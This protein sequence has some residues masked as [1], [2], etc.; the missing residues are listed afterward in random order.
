MTSERSRFLLNVAASLCQ[1]GAALATSF[2]LYRVFVDGLGV[3]GTGVWVLVATL[4]D[5]LA[6]AELG[7]GT[8]VLKF[9][10]EARGRGDEGA[11]GAVMRSSF[12]IG[13]AAGLLVLAAGG[14]LAWGLP[15]W[16]SIDA[17]LAA[18]ARLAVLV[19]AVDIALTL[20]SAPFRLALQSAQRFDVVNWVYTARWLV[21][22]AVLWA[23]LTRWPSL[24]F[25]AAV[26]L[27]CNLAANVA[28]GAAAW[29]LVPAVRAGLAR[30]AAAGWPR[31]IAG[32]AVWVAVSMIAS[33]LAYA[34]DAVLVGVFLG[35]REVALYNA[36]WRIV[37]V[38]R[39]IGQAV[40]PFFLPMA[41]ERAAGGR[42]GSVPV[43]F[44]QGVRLVVLV[45]Y[46]LVAVALGA[47]DALLA[48]WL[49]DGFAGVF[50]LLWVLLVPQV[51]IMTMYPSGPIAYGLGRQRPLVLYG[52]ATAAANLALSLVLVRRLGMLG[53]ALGTCVVLCACAAINLYFHPRLVG[54]SL[55]IYLRIVARGAL[56]LAAAVA[57]LRALRPALGD[58]ALL[59]AG[60]LAAPIVAV[61][62]LAWELTPAERADLAASLR[63]LARRGGAAGGDAEPSR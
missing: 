31:R 19:V 4:G 36:A 34:A 39:A 43:I 13:A 1:L 55:R 45:T 14:A 59:L 29:R 5:M 44:Y 57:C 50:P 22:C 33:R 56:P 62:F 11:F 30:G 27:T 24:V 51:A 35:V 10:G 7:A 9:A 23:G 37:E 16:F 28:C 63:A 54:F 25:V 2:L 21:R 15:A 32:Y 17:A 40:V 52:L 20:A 53:V 6:L 26:G 47:G 41:S 60:A 49:G 3:P 46:P 58:L 38:V 48:L 61:S 42:G 12:R 8:A 18:P